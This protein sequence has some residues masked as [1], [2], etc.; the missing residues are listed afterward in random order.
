MVYIVAIIEE[1]DGFRVCVSFSVGHIEYYHVNICGDPNTIKYFPRF[2]TLQNTM[3]AYTLALHAFIIESIQ[4]MPK[5]TVKKA[6]RMNDKK[7]L[8]PIKW[9]ETGKRPAV[10]VKK[11]QDL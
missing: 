3:I 9:A 11:F 10:Y 4:V 6:V 7:Q 2:L 8:I 5:M 1:F